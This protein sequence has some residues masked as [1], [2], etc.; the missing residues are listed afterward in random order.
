VTPSPHLVHQPLVPGSNDLF[1]FPPQS[2]AD[3]VSTGTGFQGDGQPLNF[4]WLEDHLVTAQINVI[5]PP[6]QSEPPVVQFIV[7]EDGG[8]GGGGY[9]VVQSPE[10]VATAS[11]PADKNEETRSVETPVQ[12][13]RRIKKENKS[14]LLVEELCLDVELAEKMKKMT[15]L[16]AE[17]R[18]LSR[19]TRAGSDITQTVQGWVNQAA[20]AER[21]IQEEREAVKKALNGGE[22]RKA[23]DDLL[24]K[25]VPAKKKRKAQL[26]KNVE[27]A[28]K[29][30][31][32]MEQSLMQLLRY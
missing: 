20:D 16:N 8:G 22:K 18:I 2:P 31:K 14:A 11:Q 4:P 24:K 7:P 1:N 32:Q 25:E 29:I 28:S 9:N 5:L 6:N 3:P 21:E 13:H 19:L 30:S 23:L 27:K 10:M 12:R 15:E 26:D 17:I